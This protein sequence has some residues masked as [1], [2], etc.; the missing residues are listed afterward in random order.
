MRLFGYHP[1]RFAHVQRLAALDPQTDD[2]EIYRT[3]A[4]ME[5]PWEMRFGLNLAFYRTFAAP[6]IAALLARTGEMEREPQKRA[7]DS[8][9]FMYEL[10]EHG[11]DHERGKEVVRRLN[12]MHR[13]WDIDN[14]DNLYVLAAFVVAPTRFIDENG[15]RNLTPV[16]REAAANFYRQLGRHMAIRDLPKSYGDFAALFDAYED[17]HLQPTAEARRLMAA[18]ERVLAD[19]LPR[20]LRPVAAPA[21]GALVD[22][23]LRRC[24]G[25]RPAGLAVR[26][27]VRAALVGR[28]ALVRRQPPRTSSWFEPGRA[29]SVYPEGYQMSTLGPVR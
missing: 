4:L 15:W 29:T 19:R 1:D 14:E 20:P 25:V 9:L 5:F 2:H 26:F 17:R 10:I 3:T 16:E 22:D 23:R 8:G 7:M 24:L 28:A 11:L 13:R 21:L 12:Q 6:R 27:V 18:T